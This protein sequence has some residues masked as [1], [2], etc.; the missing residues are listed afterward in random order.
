MSDRFQLFLVEATTSVF[1][2]MLGTTL[3]PR[4][5]MSGSGKPAHDIS[6]I[7]G[8]SGD[9][10]GLVTLSLSR[11]AAL[12][13]TE[14]LLGER[15]AEIDASVADTVGE[16]TNMVAGMAKGKM[17]GLTLN[18][19]LPSVVT[20]TNH[21]VVFPKEV[22]PVCIPFDSPWGPI[23]VEFGLTESVKQTTQHVHR[24]AGVV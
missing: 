20:G 17:A 2:T 14:A 24:V 5:P 3:S 19:S 15:P 9:A 16:L 18:I 23:V 6:G 8:L 22:S 12:S 4:D 7:I 1:A 21:C 13:A 11:E 10:K